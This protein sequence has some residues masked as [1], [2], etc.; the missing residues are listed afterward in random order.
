MRRF[1]KTC[2]PSGPHLAKAGVFALKLNPEWP[3]LS[4]FTTKEGQPSR[5]RL[6]R[7]GAGW[8]GALRCCPRASRGHS[9]VP[10]R[11]ARTGISSVGLTIPWCFGEGARNAGSRS[12]WPA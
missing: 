1:P 11:P 12:S 3:S 4:V 5:K 9:S 2:V 10:C 7:P 8:L 6:P